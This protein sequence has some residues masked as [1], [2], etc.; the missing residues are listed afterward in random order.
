LTWPDAEKYILKFGFCSDNSV[1]SHPPQAALAQLVE[2]SI[3][4]RKVVGSNPT[5]GSIQINRLKT[6][7][8]LAKIATHTFAHTYPMR[9]PVL[10]SIITCSFGALTQGDGGAGAATQPP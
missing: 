7:S 8:E 6:L 9:N 5:G 4:N 1:F 10:A 2:H 3:R